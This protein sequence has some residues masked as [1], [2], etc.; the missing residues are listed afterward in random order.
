MQRWLTDTS[1]RPFAMR[2]AWR[3]CG[4]FTPATSFSVPLLGAT[5]T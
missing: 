3:S 5:A 2:W 1:P 4:W